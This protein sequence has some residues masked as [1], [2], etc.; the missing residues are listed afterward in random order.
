MNGKMLGSD[1]F[2]NKYYQSKRVMRPFGRRSR[3]VCYK[4]Q[5]EPSKVPSSWYNWLHHQTDVIPQANEP[6]YSW[7]KT[8]TPNLTGTVHA[9][10]PAGHP[11]RPGKRHRATGDYQ[12]WR[13]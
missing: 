11:L 2:G 1:E 9:Y 10:Y 13:P 7:E 5:V 6:K 8:H 12:R 4:G 3:W